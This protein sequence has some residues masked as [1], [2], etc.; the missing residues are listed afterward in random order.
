MMRNTCLALGD[1]GRVSGGIANEKLPYG[2][3]Y[4]L[5]RDCLEVGES[6]RR[7]HLET[8]PLAAR[9]V[10]QIDP[11]EMKLHPIGHR[12]AALGDIGRQIDGLH[13]H[14]TSRASGVPIVVGLTND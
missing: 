2:L 9:R 13:R 11:G 4:R 10:T 12:S 6:R 3:R 5:S 8:I 14:L 7:I 1:S